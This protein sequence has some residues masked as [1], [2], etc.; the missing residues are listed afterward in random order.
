MLGQLLLIKGILGTL[1]TKTMKESVEAEKLALEHVASKLPGGILPGWFL[2]SVT[3]SKSKCPDGTW[4]VLIDVFTR[5]QLRDGERWIQRGGHRTV[6]RINPKTG[7]EMV[8]LYGT[9]NQKRIT[10]F[11]IKVDLLN[12]KCGM[13]RESDLS[14]IDK[15][16]IEIKDCDS[17]SK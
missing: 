13:L 5:R 2:P 9:S 15:S 3:T 12:S 11:E 14:I 1:A 6:A 8:E 10:L 16:E 4:V 7:E 17:D